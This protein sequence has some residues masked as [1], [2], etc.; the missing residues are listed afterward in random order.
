MGLPGGL[1]SVS[2]LG[3][4]GL[5]SFQFLWKKTAVPDPYWPGFAS[6][7]KRWQTGD[8]VSL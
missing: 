3:Y 8:S 5:V 7:E 1:C 6:L 4:K 2:Y